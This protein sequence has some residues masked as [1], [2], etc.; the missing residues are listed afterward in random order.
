MIVASVVDLAPMTDPVASVSMEFERSGDEDLVIKLKRDLKRTK[1]LLKDAH[2]FM[3]KNQQDGTSKV[4]MRQ[5]K[6]QV[7]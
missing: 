4:I 1:A 5:L 7:I 3:E 6:N 2:L